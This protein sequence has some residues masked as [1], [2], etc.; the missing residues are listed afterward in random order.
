MRSLSWIGRDFRYAVR[1]LLRDRGSVALAVLALSL[2]I[3]ATTVIFSVVDSIFINAFPFQDQSRVV[4]FFVRIG[5]RPGGSAYYLAPDFAEYRAQNAVFSKVLGGRSLEVLYTRDNATYRTRGAHLDTEALRT[6]GVVPILGRDMTAADGAPAAPPT[7]LMSERLW[8]AEFNRDPNIIGMTIKLNGV[9]RTLIA[10]LP[11][12]FLLHGADVFFPTSFTPDLTEALVGGPPN[13]PLQVWT[14]ARLK[15]GVT[16]EQAAANIAVIAQNIARAHP[17]RFPAGAQLSATVE[18]LADAYTA[19]SVK[20]MVYILAGAVLMLLMIACS[21]VANLL[22]ARATA[23]ESELAL[24]AGLGASRGRL[25]QQVLAESFVLAAVG[26]TLGAALAY[27]GL[28]WVRSAIPINGLPSE[29]QIRFSGGALL[30]TVGVTMLTALLC[31]IAPALRAARGDLQGRLTSTGKGVGGGSGRSALRWLLVAIQVTLAIV[32]LVGA[33]LLMRTL[34]AIQRVDPGFNTHNVVVAQFGFPVGRTRSPEEQALFVRRVV[35]NARTLPGVI[36]VSPSVGVPLLGTPSSPVT[37]L[38]A[39]PPERTVTAMQF[40]GEQYFQVV[41]LPLVRGRVVTQADVDGARQVAVVNREFAR[42]FLGGTDPIG[43]IAMFAAL[44]R[45]ADRSQAPQFE[46]VGVVG[47]MRRP[48]DPEDVA[49]AQAYLPYTSS[50]FG[51]NTILLRTSG[52][53]RTVP[54][55]LRRKVQAIDPEV[56]LLNIGGARGSNVLDDVLQR[57]VFDAPEFGVGLLGSFA[58]IGL[59][60]SA[61]GVVS[62]MA[63]TV[64]LQTRDIGIRMALGAQPASVMRMIVVRGL[65]P[66]VAGVV[67]GIGASYGLSRFLASHLYGVT[68]T[69]PWTFGAV[70]AVLIA[71]SVAA[72]VLPARKAMRVDPLIALRAE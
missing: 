45:G 50:P 23:H 56:A 29:M 59:I 8:S 70:I 38:G 42:Q 17:E 47:D 53:P 18:S 61:V 13:R 21:N 12:R 33:G 15:P 37:I 65:R 1:S 41:N 20:E 14:Y 9:F 36:A 10:V 66:I 22:L 43:R 27:L 30:A 28:Q 7:L 64:S 19:T 60:L 55:P 3:G 39:T 62:V 46:I 51:G 26:T 16:N 5:N 34:I 48:G 49:P 72:C 57:N 52:D 58:A 32:L 11:I 71:V 68:P 24:R 54:D 67:V 69:D 63:Y 6:L 31:G 2:G 4:H 40:V 44:S 35:E 25:M